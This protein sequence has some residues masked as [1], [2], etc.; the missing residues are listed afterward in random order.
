MS[1]PT[2]WRL[3]E[4][5]LREIALRLREPFATGAELGAG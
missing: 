4:V 5:E 1:D 2:P 3:E